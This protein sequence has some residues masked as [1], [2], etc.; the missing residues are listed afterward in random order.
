MPT[1]EEFAR[2]LAGFKGA[3]NKGNETQ[4]GNAASAGQELRSQ[5]AKAGINL[6]DLE[7]SAMQMANGRGM[8]AQEQAYANDYISKVPNTKVGG[9]PPSTGG[10]TPNRYQA[11]SSQGKTTQGV[12]T[13]GATTYG[14]ANAPGT[15]SQLAQTLTSYNN[16]NSTFENPGVGNNGVGTATGMDAFAKDPLL[17]QKEYDRTNSVIQNR[18]GQ[19]LGIEQQQGWL[20]QLLQNKPQP[21]KPPTPASGDVFSP[22]GLNDRMN[23]Q[24][25]AGGAATPIDPSRFNNPDQF[26]SYIETLNNILSPIGEQQKAGITSSYNKALGGLR[27]QW[28]SRGLLASGEA[29][30]QERQGMEGLISQLNGVDVTRLQQAMQMAPEWARIGLSESG[31]RFDQNNTNREF[32]QARAN[33]AVQNYLNALKNQQDNQHWQSEFG[34]KEN[35]QGFEQGMANKDFGLK[36]G[37][38]TGRY[39]PYEAR[40]ILSTIMNNKGAW[41]KTND[42]A[43]RQK[44]SGANQDLYRQLDLMGIDSKLVNGDV[45][46]DQALKNVNGLYKNTLGQN[47]FEFDKTKW[48]DQ[49]EWDKSRFGQEHE[50][51]KKNYEL[52]NWYKRESALINWDS[53]Q[54]A[55]DKYATEKQIADETKKATQATQRALTDIFGD[56][57]VK[58]RE[59]AI[60]KVYDQRGSW[61]DLGVDVGLIIKNIDAFYNQP[62]EASGGG[63]PIGGLGGPK[64]LTP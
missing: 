43:E 6:N 13:T 20:Q 63:S 15:A 16:I 33:Q 59:Q 28:A 31:Q 50:L 52:D 54:L 42:E 44:L 12:T 36:E 49:L 40:G 11:P 26:K 10:G 19:G 58:T 30:A 51:D 17:W 62:K 3:Y 23:N 29:A 22:G 1:L 4:K 53:N 45:T 34:L 35:Q 46:L 21:V 56:P 57:S 41:G 48:N 61:T 5:A 2:Q 8:N 18:T 37:Q 55:K 27:D 25:G 60:R 47:Q 38:L 24:E 14:S 7:S 64:P 32:D 39:L 9:P